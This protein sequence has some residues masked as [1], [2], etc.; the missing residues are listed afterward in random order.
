MLRGSQ[1][2]AAVCRSPS[3]SLPGSSAMGSTLASIT[4]E[5]NDIDL[6]L[7]DATIADVPLL[8]A[9]FRSMAAFEQLTLSATEESVRDALFGEAP[10][11]RALLACV[12]SKPI[13]YVTYFFT[14]STMIGKRGLWLEDLF[15]DPP[16]RGKGIGRALMGH[17][18]KIAVENQC[19]RFEWSV[20][21]W[22]EPA[23]RFYERLGATLLNDWRICRLDE[24]QMSRVA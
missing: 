1:R 19:G 24:A 14:F 13:A 6:E 12:D 4:M 21:D 18:A 5:V 17:L 20:L 15:I 22:N 3:W 16:F 23:I 2:L 9:F 11:A 7:R 8:L 10:A